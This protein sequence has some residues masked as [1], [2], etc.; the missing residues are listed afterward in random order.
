MRHY[1]MFFKTRRKKPAPR[2][3]PVA[4]QRLYSKGKLLISQA[5]FIPYILQHN[6]TGLF[7]PIEG[8]C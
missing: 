4:V 5:K 2:R 3:R 7:E 1:T 6:H 8:R